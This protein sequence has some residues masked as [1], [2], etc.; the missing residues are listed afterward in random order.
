[1][2]M[3]DKCCHIRIT[4]RTSPFYTNAEIFF[5]KFLRVITRENNKILTTNKISEALSYGSN[6]FGAS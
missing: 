1:M 5:K 3:S 2:T 4:Y 6:F